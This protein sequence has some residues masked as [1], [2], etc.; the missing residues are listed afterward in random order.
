MYKIDYSYMKNEFSGDRNYKIEFLNKVVTVGYTEKSALQAIAL[1]KHAK[2]LEDMYGKDI[3]DFDI[4]ELEALLMSCSSPSVTSL[5]AIK[6]IM[7]KYLLNAVD[8]KKSKFSVSPTLSIRRNRLKELI[9]K[10]AQ[11]NRLCTKKEFYDAVNT[12]A[13][14]QDKALLICIWHGFYNKGYQMIRDAKENSVNF[15]NNTITMINAETGEEITKQ[16][17]NEDMMI[18]K[19]ALKEESYIKSLENEYYYFDTEYLFKSFD[20][21][22]RRDRE[23]FRIGQQSIR[24][25]IRKFQKDT[26]LVFATGVTIKLSGDIYR[27]LE[28][29]GYDR[30][31]SQQD[32]A[33]Y[34]KTNGLAYNNVNFYDNLQVLQKKYQKELLLV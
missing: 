34:I 17:S 13:N 11:Y 20:F 15:D 6:S 10:D 33:E 14:Y 32:T 31:Y 5:Q 9:F 27:L 16:L 22:R 3:Y 19:L 28:E 24:D 30:E 29:Y 1:F 21:G 4:S 8:E 23:D 26:G 18:F 12:I 7:D 2:D 25:K